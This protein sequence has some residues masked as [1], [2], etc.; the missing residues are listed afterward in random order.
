MWSTKTVSRAEGDR[1]RER[2]MQI[3]QSH[4]K[5]KSEE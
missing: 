5:N 4:V 1:K 2:E 3:D